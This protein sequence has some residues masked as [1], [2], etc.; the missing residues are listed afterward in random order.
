M[1]ALRDEEREC[2]MS[3]HNQQGG[4]TRSTAAFL[5]PAFDEF[6]LGYRDRGDALVKEHA[7]KV[8]PGGNDVFRSMAVV[9][10]QITG[11]WRRKLTG[12]GVEVTVAAFSARDEGEQLWVES[13]RAY[14][15]F[16]VLPLA[17]TR[18][19]RRP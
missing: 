10:G 2:W 9:D 7:A 1:L 15:D 17:S 5:L 3:D 8:S 12:D 16:L 19:E 14:A 13:A 11:T 18:I 4:G 6:L